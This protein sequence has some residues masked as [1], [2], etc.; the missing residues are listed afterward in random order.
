MHRV[1]A[2]IR[3][4]R[5]FVVV[6][7]LVVL[8]ATGA[9]PVAADD[10][11]IPGRLIFASDRSGDF[12]VYVMDANGS[13][14]TNL[15]NHPA[16]DL[17][18]AWSPDGKRIAFARGSG[19]GRELYVMNADGSNPVRLTFNSLA[20]VQPVWSPSGKELAFVRF[21]SD[22]NRD[23]YVMS[24]EPNGATVQVTDDP[25]LFDILPDWA[26]SGRIAFSSDRGPGPDDNAVF[27]VKR[28]GSKVKRLTPP[29]LFA[30]SPGWS[31]DGGAIAAAD[32]FCGFCPE[33]DIVVVDIG[34]AAVKR[35]TDSP[36]NDLNP[37]FSPDGDLIAFES[38]TL[39]IPEPGDFGPPDILVIPA[40]GG[41]AVNL[42]NDPEST[43][44]QPDWEP[45]AN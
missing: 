32:N 18:P 24:A 29:E 22:Q 13:H 34:S 9:S 26:P 12:E 2:R 25:A 14:L 6:S 35:L 30:G 44:I 31:P 8:A 41:Q 3:A 28:D 45:R 37:D 16:N 20:D 40:G 43:D 17:F 10:L 39:D 38:G 36:E 19:L 21:G 15:T 42:T 33:S 1:T 7:T 11:G 5:A 4:T 27:S 23:L